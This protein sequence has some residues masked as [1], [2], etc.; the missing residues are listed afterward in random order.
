M[1]D[2]TPE[3]FPNYQ[4]FWNLCNERPQ[5]MDIHCRHY[6]L[7]PEGW[8]DSNYDPWP[9]R[10]SYHFHFFSNWITA[11][12]LCRGIMVFW[13]RFPRYLHFWISFDDLWYG[14]L[15]HLHMYV[16]SSV[17]IAHGPIKSLTVKSWLLF[18]WMVKATFSALKVNSKK[19]V[20]VNFIK[21][22]FFKRK[23]LTT[24]FLRWVQLCN[25]GKRYC[26]V[27]VHWKYCILM[28]IPAL[29]RC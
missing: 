28:K 9:E 11:N 1:F 14:T 18:E 2:A 29:S 25:W 12:I 7:E 4:T 3:R 8:A 13:M 21:S 17:L 23:Q 22:S 16:Y 15:L 19:Y 27:Y 10:F 6:E 5:D 20:S 24:F 26:I